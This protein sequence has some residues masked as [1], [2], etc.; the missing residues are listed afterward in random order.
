[1]TA[2]YD[3][4]RFDARFSYAWRDRYLAQFSDDFGI[5]RFTDSFGQLDFSSNYNIND[6]FS[7]QFQAL[8][9][10][11]A[12]TINQSTGAYIPYGVSE[13]DR[14]FLFGGRVKF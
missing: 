10:T 14:R 9:L 8:N 11:R 5:P 3:D 6:S 13:L 2:Y 12:Q 1:L 7:V 4:G